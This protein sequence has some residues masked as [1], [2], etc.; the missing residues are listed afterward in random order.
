MSSIRNPLL[1]KAVWC[2]R[3][4]DITIFCGMWFSWYK[5]NC[6]WYKNG[7]LDCPTMKKFFWTFIH[8]L[9]LLFFAN[10]IVSLITL[11]WKCVNWNRSTFYEQFP[12][13]F[14]IYGSFV[15]SLSFKQT[16]HTTSNLHTLVWN[17]V[18]HTVFFSLFIA[19][20]K[21]FIRNVIK[22]E[23]HKNPFKGKPTVQPV[24]QHYSTRN[25]LPLHSQSCHIS[26]HHFIS[27]FDKLFF[28]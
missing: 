18:A 27:Q 25:C 13:T 28:S 8:R 16:L 10:L 22:N 4:F 20:I 11:L 5:F 21:R 26:F 1:E 6:R 15:F 17:W 7:S 9:K 24:S 19:M 14:D 2:I 3:G 23:R 12:W